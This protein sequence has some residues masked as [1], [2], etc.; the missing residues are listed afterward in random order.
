MCHYKGYM[1]NLN[2]AIPFLDPTNIPPECDII[3]YNSLTI[4][5]S[6]K[7][8]IHSNILNKLMCLN[9]T[10][11][12]A[13]KRDTDYEG[14]S[15]ILTSDGNSVEAKRLCDFASMYNIKGFIIKELAPTT[16]SQSLNINIG[17]FVLP[18]LKQ[19]KCC[20]SF[21]IGVNIEAYAPFVKNP[22]VYNFEEMNKLVNFYDINTYD[23]N[24][25]NPQ[26]YNGRTPLLQSPHGACYMLGMQE[27]T[28]FL[29]ASKINYDMIYYTL[30]LGPIN[31]ECNSYVSYNQVCLGSY[32]INT[33]CIQTTKDYYA[34]GQYI[35]NEKCGLSIKWIELDDILN[36]CKCIPFIG[37]QNAV[38][39]YLGKSEIP[40]TN[41]N[42]NDNKGNY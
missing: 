16:Y 28:T 34:K 20:D 9:K 8:R 11:L 25:C 15:D 40:C 36:N 38:A 27:V 13:I 26:Q 31:I 41:F 1:N 32:N 2:P 6:S 30:E 3:V 22:C 12:V 18:Y 33:W 23:L 19:L 39:G 17:E 14:W 42:A 4:N 35:S 7:L 21:I 5:S 37:F 24:D 10:L 29:K